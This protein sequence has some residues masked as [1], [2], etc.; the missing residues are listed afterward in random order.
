LCPSWDVD[1]FVYPIGMLHL[2]FWV[3]TTSLYN[4]KYR[5]E[6]WK[7]SWSDLRLWG[8]SGD[9]PC[10]N[11]GRLEGCNLPWSRWLGRFRAGRMGIF[12][13]LVDISIINTHP[14]IFILFRFKFWISETIWV[15]HF[16]NKIVSS[17]LA[18]SL[19]YILFVLA[20]WRRL[21]LTSLA[22]GSSEVRALSTP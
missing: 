22:F 20:K 18:I 15:I 1:T 5:T 4:K 12:A 17:S 11:L 2:Y 9:T 13:C 10:S 14:P 6:W 19:Y 7:T 3:W 21:C 8:E 16:F